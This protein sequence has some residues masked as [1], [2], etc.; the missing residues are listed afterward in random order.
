MTLQIMVKKLYE[1][2]CQGKEREE[3]HQTLEQTVRQGCASQRSLIIKNPLFNDI[4][5]PWAVN[6]LHQMSDGSYDEGACDHYGATLGSFAT[7]EYAWAIPSM[8]AVST[9]LTYKQN[10]VEVGSG[11]GYW[12][13]LLRAAGGNVIAIDD[14]SEKGDRTCFTDIF[15]QNGAKYLCERSGAKDAMLFIC[16]GRYDIGTALTEFKGD[17]LAVVGEKSGCTWWPEG[18]DIGP[19]DNDE[20]SQLSESRQEEWKCIQEVMIPRWDMI[21]DVLAIFQRN[22]VGP[23]S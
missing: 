12:A 8:E 14:G 21:Y 5:L 18:V 16:W 11:Q 9:I 22:P 6:R 15:Y 19:D 7:R 23:D 1:T 10:I 17:Y 13:S 2:I 3:K 4:W 20:E